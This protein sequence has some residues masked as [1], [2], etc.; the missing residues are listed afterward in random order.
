MIAIAVITPLGARATS[1][2]DL[3]HGTTAGR[4]DE[5]RIATRVIRA[6]PALG[7]GPEGY[8]VVF[9]QV[10]DAE[11]E[12]EYG[13]AVYPD[14]A[15]NGILDVTLTGGLL[16]GLLYA[17]LL[18]LALAARVAAHCERAIRSTRHSVPRSSRTSCSNS[19]CSRS[20]S[21]IR[22]SGCSSA[23]WSHERRAAR[24]SQ[25]CAPAGSSSPSRSRPPSGCTSARGMCW[26]IAS[27]G[28]RRDRP[29]ASAALRHADAATRLRPDSIRAWYAAARI[30]QRGDALTDVDAALDRVLVGLDRSP[31]DPALRVLYGELL[32]ERATR[33]LLPT[34]IAT[35]QSELGRMVAGAPHDPRLRKDLVTARSLRE[36]G[37][38]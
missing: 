36:I 5:W 26:P 11:Y 17:A 33:S 1:T 28:G 25:R 14:R 24:R 37:K 31:G 16:A 23:C 27:C 21:S 18:V 19:S 7:V 8:R 29:S 4:F 3:E 38:P 9:P 2:F 20:P 22:S 32:V 30:A 10:V 12:R 15:H 6:E 35:A 34:D 13:V